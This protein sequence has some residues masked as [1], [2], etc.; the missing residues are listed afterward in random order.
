M[1]SIHKNNGGINL[2]GFIQY[3]ADSDATGTWQ[4]DNIIPPTGQLPSERGAMEDIHTALGVGGMIPGVGI[5][6]DLIDAGLYGAEG[7][8]SGGLLS[9]L[10]ATPLFG[11]A[12]G[13][14]KNVAKKGG[15][16][17]YRGVGEWHKGKM[18][19]EGMHVSP[20]NLGDIAGEANPTKTGIWATPDRDQALGY[21]DDDFLE[22]PQ[23]LEYEVPEEWFE[24]KATK[25]FE[26]Y[27]KGLLNYVPDSDWIEGGIPKQYFKKRH[28]LQQ[29]WKSEYFPP[30]EDMEW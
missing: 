7:D 22:S 5:V 8:Y 14:L 21:I 19:K 1:A 29:G 27:G 13:G 28:K 16:K 9:L 3:P 26:D 6:P 20:E 11:L 17:L 25:Q 2:E 15:K 12:A 10:A 30:F 24:E 4:Q 23:L 18:V